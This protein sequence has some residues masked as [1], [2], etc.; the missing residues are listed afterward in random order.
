MP[1]IDPSDPCPCG[2][3]EAYAECCAADGAIAAVTAAVQWLLEHHEEAVNDALN[4]DYLGGLDDEHYERLDE[5]P[6]ELAQLLEWNAFEWLLAEGEI[7]VDGGPR[8]VSELLLGD[9]GPE[10]GEAQRSYLEALAERPLGLYQVDEAVAGEGLWVEDVLG[11]E[12]P[13]RQWVAA[14]DLADLLEPGYV[15]GLRLLPGEAWETTGALYP[16]PDDLYPTLLADLRERLA[17]AADA[18]EERETLSVLMVDGWLEV[19][20]AG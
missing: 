2:S 14:P 1:P 16:V 12:Q 9:G 19:I 15:L 18:E 11:R 7:E 17:A 5:L 13:A 6:E 10:L 3:G 4:D 20:T 8:R